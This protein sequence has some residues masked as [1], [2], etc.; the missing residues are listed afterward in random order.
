MISTAALAPAP[1]FCAAVAAGLV[2]DLFLRTF[3]ALPAHLVGVPTVIT[4]H[5]KALVGNVLRDCRNEI[6]R[7]EYLEVALDLQ[8]HSRAIENGIS[9]TIHLHLRH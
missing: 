4:H 3:P 9:R 2:R 7:R 1:H 5:L 6:T 8:I